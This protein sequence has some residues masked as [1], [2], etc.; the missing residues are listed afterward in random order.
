VFDERSDAGCFVRGELHSAEPKKDDNQSP[1]EQGQVGSSALFSDL[2][3]TLV[4][5]SDHLQ[6]LFEL[7]VFRPKSSL[8]PWR[9]NCRGV[10]EGRRPPSDNR[11][12]GAH[13][14]NGMSQVQRARLR[15]AAEIVSATRSSAAKSS[16][17]T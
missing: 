7:Y 2:K 6:S 15:S 12:S 8:T 4:C 14:K 17:A 10:Q 16:G 1:S 13:R 9:S 5:K 11:Y 3:T